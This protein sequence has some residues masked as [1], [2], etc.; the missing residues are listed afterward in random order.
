M[1]FPL[2]ATLN[3]Q[4]ANTTQVNKALNDL[5]RK[6]DKGTKKAQTFSDVVSF[7][8]TNFAAYTVASAAVLKLTGAIAGA[9]Q[10]ALRLEKE[11]VKIG[12]VIGVS[13]KQAL[14]LSSSVLEISK[15]YG[16]SSTK[17]AETIRT[18]TQSGIAFDKARKAADLLAKTTLLATFDSL[19]STTEGLV[20]I[21]AQFN[22]SVKEAEG[23]IGSIN[24]LSKNYA[25]ESKD[26]ID[27]VKRAGGV[28]SATGSSLEDL[29]A[30][31]TTVRSTTR[32]SS[33]TISTGLRTIFTRIQRPK[34]IEYF[35]QLGAELTN[36]EG[37]FIGNLPAIQLISKR[38]EELGIRAGDIKFAEV[39]EQLGGIRQATRVIPLLT[40]QA[41]LA[42]TVALANK[43]LIETD[44]DVAKA[45]QT[46]AF[47]IEE[48]R[49]RFNALVF[50]ITQNVSFK[51][52][53]ETLFGMANALLS[54]AD[55]LKPLIPLLTAFAAIKLGSLVG[56]T[57]KSF[58]GSG[59]G[60]NSVLG[61]NRGGTV[62][63]S[64]NGDTV[65]AMLESGEFVVRKSA[66]QAFG[67]DRLAGINKYA[68]GGQVPSYPV[69][70]PRKPINLTNIR[71]NEKIPP[72]T[73]GALQGLIFESDMGKA[74]YNVLAGD[75]PDL[76]AKDAKRA[77]GSQLSDKQKKKIKGG[78]L[79]Y[80]KNNSTRDKYTA[81]LKR[82]G[83]N[84][85]AYPLIV[86]QLAKGGPV[87]TD[88]TPA[89][90]TPGEVVIN[91]KSAQDFG[92]GNLEKINKYAKGGIVGPQKFADGGIA[93]GSVFL[94][95]AGLSGLSDSVS[96]L[97]SSFAVLEITTGI[98]TSVFQNMA[99]VSSGLLKSYK[100][101]SDVRNQTKERIKDF[102]ES[103]SKAN[104]E[105]A[106][107]SE[108]S[109]KQSSTS[110]TTAGN[111]AIDAGN[112]VKDNS[113]GTGLLEDKQAQTEVQN[114]LKKLGE[115]YGYQS[116]EVSALTTT[117]QQFKGNDEA[118][119][120]AASAY[121]SSL[122]IAEEAY[123]ESVTVIED[124]IQSQKDLIS[125]LNSRIDIEKEQLKRGSLKSK[126]KNFFGDEKQGQSRK[127]AA[128]QA[129]DKAATAALAIFISSLSRASD[130]AQKLA[131]SSIKAGNAEEAAKQTRIAIE[132][133]NASSGI[134][135]GAAGG[136]AIGTLIG[137]FW[138]PV[139]AQVGGTIGKV[140]GSLIGMTGAIDVVTDFL[141]FTNSEAEK[142]AAIRKAKED[143]N[144]AAIS[145]L[146]DKYRKESQILEKTSITEAANRTAEGIEAI[147]NE[148]AKG[149][150]TQNAATQEK[151]SAASEELFRQ[152]TELSQKPENLG[153]TFEQLSKEN[154]K[155][156]AGFQTLSQTMN[157]SS[158]SIHEG[159]AASKQWRD[160]TNVSAQIARKEVNAKERGIAIFLQ[161]ISIQ[162]QLNESLLRL[163]DVLQ[164]QERAISNL[165]F[166]LTGSFG[167]T[168]IGSNLTN[169]DKAG[170]KE[171]QIG[172]AEVSKLGPE[173]ASEA[174]KI[175]NGISAF[176][177]FAESLRDS[178]EVKI[179]LKIGKK[180]EGLIGNKEIEEI[181]ERITEFK[182]SGG[183]AGAA[184]DLEKELI[185]K[186]IAPLAGSLEEGRELINEANKNYIEALNK[187]NQIEQESIKRKLDIITQEQESF[188]KI[189]QLLGRDTTIT[190]ARGQNN[191]L[192]ASALS[193]T[194]LGITGNRTNDLNA[195]A[196][197]LKRNRIEAQ[198]LQSDKNS[199]TLS[200]DEL[201]NV[202]KRFT[203]L[204]NESEKLENA[205]KIL[206]DTTSENA[207][208]E[209]K[210]N[211]SRKERE[212][213]R[214]TATSLAFGTNESRSEFFKNLQSA[215]ILSNTSNTGLIAE[216]R[217]GGTLQLL[218]KFASSRSFN[219]KT[220]Q[221]VINAST[222]R[223]LAS[224]GVPLDQIGEV[225]D[226]F[227]AS[228]LDMITAIQQN[229]R[230]DIDRNKKLDQIASLIAAN[231]GGFASGGIVYA[232]GGSLVNFQKKGTDTVPAMLTPGEFVIKRDSVNK[233]GTGMMESIN[234]GN[235]HKGGAV[236][237]GTNHIHEIKSKYNNSPF[238]TGYAHHPQNKKALQIQE[239]KDLLPFLS[240]RQLVM[241]FDD[242]KSEF[243][244]PE[245][246]RIAAEVL[247]NRIKVGRLYINERKR[248]EKERKIQ[249]PKNLF[250]NERTLLEQ[251]EYNEK[252][253]E[254]EAFYKSI[255]T[256]AL[257]PYDVAKEKSKDSSDGTF[258]GNLL[259]ERI[260]KQKA[261]RERA[262]EKNGFSEEYGYFPPKLKR[263][264]L[265][266]NYG[267]HLNPTERGYSVTTSSDGLTQRES[268][269]RT[270]Q[271]RQRT[272]EDIFNR[273]R[274]ANVDPT[275]LRSRVNRDSEELTQ[276]QKA[277]AFGRRRADEKRRS[278]IN[279]AY[280]NRI[281]SGR[282]LY[283]EPT[284]ETGIANAKKRKETKEA[285]DAMI[286]QQQ[287]TAQL[288]Y[289]LREE[290]E[291]NGIFD[292]QYGTPNSTSLGSLQVK[293]DKKDGYRSKVTGKL[294]EKGLARERKRQGKTLANKSQENSGIDFS[295]DFDPI[296]KDLLITP[297]QAKSKFLQAAFTKGR[298]LKK[299]AFNEELIKQAFGV[300]FP[301]DRADKDN[302]GFINAL[303]LR[304]LNPKNYRR[305]IQR[306]YDSS[307]FNEKYSEYT[308]KLYGLN[309]TGSSASYS[310]SV[311]SGVLMQGKK[312]TPQFNPNMAFSTSGKETLNDARP[313][314]GK[315]IDAATKKGSIPYII[316]LLSNGQLSS[317]A[318]D[319]LSGI[320]THLQSFNTGGKVMGKSGIDTN[321]AMLTRGEYVV[322]KSSVDK[323]GTSMMEQINKGKFKGFARGGSVGGD[324][325]SASPP[326]FSLIEPAQLEM[327]RQSFAPFISA[328][329]DL[330]SMPK[331]IQV[332]MGPVNVSVNHNGLEIFSTIQQ[333]TKNMIMEA[334]SKNFEKIRQD[335]KSGNL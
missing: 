74:N 303:E 193:G 25:V 245:V 56:K 221:E 317:N 243:P 286:A 2:A 269:A 244:Y 251:E 202:T 273:R 169:L 291:A 294:T 295:K 128:A 261:E 262:R 9:T 311:I 175:K 95:N 266:E 109:E 57:V 30:I 77:I 111:V 287:R 252:V 200:F 208:I 321:P 68:G 308:S 123:E 206:A 230:I 168:S 185:E 335:L 215:N 176:D 4:S 313:L 240:N 163:R 161:Q 41:K 275:D 110:A 309:D 268:A 69:K 257:N 50:D 184:S 18:L 173:F 22:V 105:I 312:I 305:I 249:E 7:K 16:V 98:T 31:F 53:T 84:K 118:R 44:K 187:R 114:R 329:N 284:T 197:E 126:V 11:L 43:G 23:A 234:A 241:D 166:A 83:Y 253:K 36:L 59:S 324:S 130:A 255:Q 148:A 218:Q 333:E 152:F 263:F 106:K 314:L 112:F 135:K 54:V 24:A 89:L 134:Q 46:V 132:K 196:N 182:K 48:L 217:R 246:S 52:L 276:N 142:Q 220:G 131:D 162:D 332:Q 3:I 174:N 172:L 297:R 82:K 5:N 61:F 17:V 27:A 204:Q 97:V 116:K 260:A 34:T 288:N 280:Q 136:A 85:E 143:A 159:A 32:E 334:V 29:L 103:I 87:G 198:K 12:Q 70:V 180:L 214:D 209:K 274:S 171:F 117:L 26:L 279:D 219:G 67:A 145:N 91:K 113:F 93:G 102:E 8:A 108:K 99:S 88:T 107:L 267:S 331:E 223:F 15:S 236:G 167:E 232:S 86:R 71:N 140:V 256:P 227:I 146:S 49:A 144:I 33:E 51:V 264:E 315:M 222:S 81:A 119:R 235:F 271:S 194:G 186:Y 158:T 207:S 328:V 45:K 299:I 203:D 156:A 133:K 66:V 124:G 75:F 19:Q 1:A 233:Y 307:T 125:A 278:N 195:L 96:S 283:L 190:Q 47:R 322:N 272:Q 127:I 6:L 21:F 164:N 40:Q 228:E 73:K 76:S 137:A 201:Q 296:F 213:K 281:D 94:G 292:V 319:T 20:A 325:S 141:G 225:M 199:G 58:S 177:G 80:E 28:F 72:A 259:R 178:S 318:N 139:G 238:G 306:L 258:T 224:I 92:Y 327:I 151:L 10:E 290:N 122:K 304:K 13:N 254:H 229:Y 301:F 90:L 242:I 188:N 237:H 55:A 289:E 316:N 265:E 60:S 62:P 160:V 300:A 189:S 155:I 63:G 270:A 150:G 37:Q 323:Y 326:S 277:Y 42:D 153:K 211:E 302:D 247:N 79:K 165:D 65:P 138:G 115:E 101:E 14:S 231:A 157:D 210:L 100:E 239:F 78:E 154:P 183:G 330:I 205:M 285:V 320:N 120:E 38:L 310:E 104:T 181:K 121:V 129:L 64:G 293:K 191:K 192:A 212:N 35:R 170:T 39:V 282:K 250:S 179:G 226:D 298:H 149:S 216:S 248:K 147:V